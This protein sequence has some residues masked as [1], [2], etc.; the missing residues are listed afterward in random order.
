[1]IFLLYI[2]RHLSYFPDAAA[3]CSFL[4]SIAHFIC[5]LSP[6]FAYF[7]MERKHI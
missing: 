7:L 4:R 6:N 2:N 5:V 1:M 3:T